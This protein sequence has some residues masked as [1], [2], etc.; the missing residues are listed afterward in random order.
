MDSEQQKIITEVASEVRQKLEGEDSGH[1]WWHIVR[2]WNTA[3]HIG[4][5]ENAD[6]FIV[7]LA[8]LLQALARQAQ[9][10]GAGQR[11]VWIAG[12]LGAGLGDGEQVRAEVAA[13]HRGHITRRQR[14]QGPGVVPVQEVA[15]VPLHGLQGHEGGFEPVEQLQRADPAELA[16]AGG[17]RRRRAR[18]RAGV[19]PAYGRR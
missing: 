4:A 11:G 6:I 12:Q 17:R 1:D 7:E 14:L 16:R 2:V 3:K 8:A 9:R 10:P 18:R 15:P 19:N 5:A 13:V